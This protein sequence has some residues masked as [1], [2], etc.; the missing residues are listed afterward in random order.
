VDHKVLVG[1]QQVI[2]KQEVRHKLA[3]FFMV[4]LVDHQVAT[5]AA[6]AEAAVTTVAAEAVGILTTLEQEVA[7]EV[8]VMLLEL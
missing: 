3:V 8:Q 6:V 2:H 5:A 1:M 7:V 4:V